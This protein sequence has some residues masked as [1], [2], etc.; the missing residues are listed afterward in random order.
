MRLRDE[1]ADDI[2][3]ILDVQFGEINIG[4][5]IGGTNTAKIGEGI[6]IIL[7]RS[8]EV[9]LIQNYTL[10]DR[11]ENLSDIEYVEST[12]DE[13]NYSL[14][15]LDFKSCRTFHLTYCSQMYRD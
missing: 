9:G 2:L 1:V 14:A 8:I 4:Q 6:R 13:V 5:P 11:F 7:D 10:D 12:F 3:R 15:Y